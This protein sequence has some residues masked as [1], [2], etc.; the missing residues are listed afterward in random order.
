MNKKIRLTESELVDL[1]KKIVKEQEADGPA[2]K[3]VSKPSTSSLGERI[4][5]IQIKMILPSKKGDQTYLASLDKVKK[6]KDGCEFEGAF[7]GDEKRQSFHYKCDGALFWKQG[8][9]SSSTEVEISADAGKLLMKACGCQAY[10]S[11]QT[12]AGM[13]SQMAEDEEMNEAAPEAIETGEPI[14][15]Y[16]FQFAEGSATPLNAF[17]RPGKSSREFSQKK[18]QEISTNIALDL[19]TSGTIRVIEKYVRSG[20]LPPFIHI[21]V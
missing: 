7:R 15:L 19:K 10:A 18:I 13:Q 8:M 1:V 5:P 11:N 3:T 6:V 17:K 4:N 20:N 14:S 21:H 2:P 16:F 12:T 9:L